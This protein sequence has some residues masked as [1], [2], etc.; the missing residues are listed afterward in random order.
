MNND[1]SILFLVFC[2]NHRSPPTYNF[3]IATESY[4][5]ITNEE[6]TTVQIGL[7]PRPGHSVQIVSPILEIPY[8]SHISRL[9]QITQAERSNGDHLGV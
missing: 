9:H 7:F 5:L 2:S 6:W 3:S 8:R 4:D 1:G